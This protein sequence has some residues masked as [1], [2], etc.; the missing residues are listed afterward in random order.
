MEHSAYYFIF[1]ITHSFSI[2]EGWSRNKV[3]KELQP[4]K[5][6]TKCILDSPWP[7]QQPSGIEVPLLIP[8]F[9]FCKPKEI[10][11]WIFFC[12]LLELYRDKCL[13]VQ[14]VPKGWKEFSTGW[15]EFLNEEPSRRL[16]FR[17]RLLRWFN[18]R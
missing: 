16:Q 14:H 5:C 4:R 9:A 18:S 13:S 17:R 2:Y 6:G 3:T 7:N 12:R 15:K 10:H 1:V 11:L 8:P